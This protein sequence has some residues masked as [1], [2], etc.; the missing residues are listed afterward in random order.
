LPPHLKSA[1]GS[2]TK[3]PQASVAEAEEPK[4]SGWGR[5]CLAAAAL[6][7]LTLSVAATLAVAVFVLQRQQRSATD[8]TSTHH[9]PHRRSVADKANYIDATRK[10]AVLSG[11]SVRVDRA[12][13]GKVHYRS[14]GEILETATK[15]YLVL[16]LNV[17]NRSRSEPVDYRSWY[18][19]RFTAADDDESGEEIQ[20]SAPAETDDVQLIDENDVELTLFRIPGAENVERH[21]VSEVSLPPGDDIADTLVFK[22]PDGYLDEPIPTLYLRLPVAA[23]GDE[24]FFKLK[25]PGAMVFRRD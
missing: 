18:D 15:N 8:G 2:T 16:T 13:A 5:G 22:L 11:V 14:K 4:S 24:G 10:A 19:N 17:K 6:A 23:V 7:I 3:N 1:S 25:L 20:H 9:P 21:A 12:E